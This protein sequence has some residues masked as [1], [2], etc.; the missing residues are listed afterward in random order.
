VPASWTSAS[1]YAGRVHVASLH[2]YPVKSCRG[3]DVDVWP[4]EVRGLRY[5]R[6][7]MVVRPDG[8]VITQRERPVLATIATALHG[9][10]APGGV[11]ELACP[12]HGAVRV[13][14][15]DEG[16][17]PL[18]VTVWRSRVVARTVDPAIDRWL[19]EIVGEPLR[20]VRFCESEH[21]PTNPRYAPG[22]ETAFADGYPVLVLSRASLDD[23]NARMPTP[24]PMDRFRPNLVAG[25]TAAFAEDRWGDLAVGQAEIRVVKPCARCVIV[26]TD[27]QTG[28]TSVEPLRTLA[29]FRRKDHEVLFGQNA[30]VTRPGV[31]GVGDPL[32]A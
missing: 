18:E 3:I 19:G 21:R 13:A 28:A 10:L 26:T 25:G 17:E 14:L 23:L 30:V 12:G 5:D 27:Q 9:A 1:S 20:L 22:F 11:L 8:A 7:F 29:T 2:V 32:S 24:V 4:L 15:D 31:I 16:G 6:R